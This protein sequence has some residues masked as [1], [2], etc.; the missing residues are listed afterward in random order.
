MRRRRSLNLRWPGFMK[1]WRR[2]IWRKS[3]MR[4]WLGYLKILAIVKVLT[5]IEGGNDEVEDRPWRPSHVVFGKSSVKQ[6]QIEAMKGRYFR[7]ISIV[8][9]RGESIVPL[10][11][12]NEV[13][14]FR[15]FMKV[16]L[17]FP[18]HKMLVEVLKTFEIYL[19]QLIP[20]ALIKVV[21][22]IWA[23]RSQ[24]LELDAKCFCNI[25][26]L[27][28]QMKAT[29]KEQYHNNFGCYSFVPHSGASYPV[30]TFRKKWPGSWMQEWFYVKNDLDQR[31]DIRGII[32][33][34]IW[35]CFDIRRP[36]VTLGNDVQACQTAFNIVCTYIGTRDLIQEHI[37]YRVWPL[38]SGWEM[39]KE[40]AAGSS[41]SGLIYLKYTFRFRD[42]FDEPNDDWLDAI[43]ATSDELLGA[44]SRA[45]DEAMIM[46][47]GARGK[48]RLNR[49][50][51]VIGFIYPDYCF[52]AQKYKGKRK[53]PLQRLLVRRRQRK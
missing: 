42:R 49:G 13:V 24:G 37:A 34:P 25:H 26:E 30:P 27:S 9:D 23:M 2:Q 47:F 6:G 44:Y 3:P 35:S 5:Y 21:V 7:D 31:E 52:P 43:E 28:Y 40:A 20:E 32:Q 53:L 38:A 14:V 33:C 11:K 4:C 16:G 19:H 18:L 17:R 45:E 22:F 48:K 46:A 50:F 8:T 1:L 39:P 15:S 41:Q 36:S 29:G 12:A 10:P 51:D